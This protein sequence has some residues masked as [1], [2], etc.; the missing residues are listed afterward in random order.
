MDLSITYKLDFLSL[1]TQNL[2]LPVNYWSL[3]II[4][5]CS[6]IRTSASLKSKVRRS[7]GVVFDHAANACAQ[8]SAACKAN[9]L[10]A[11]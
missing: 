11:P 2:T 6:V 1:V 8:E 9:Y 7:I 4:Y 3:K 5:V 10:V